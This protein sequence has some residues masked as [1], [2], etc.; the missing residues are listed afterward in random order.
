MK[1]IYL[2]LIGLGTIGTGVVKVLSENREIIRD[3]LGAELVLKKIADLDID[4]DRG[5][6]ID[7]SILTRDAGEVINDP[8]ISIVI[9]LIG[10]Y[11]PA[12]SFILKAMDN[13]KNIIT[14]NKALL[15]T[16]GREIFDKASEKGVG[17]AFEA[18]V[19]GGIPI[20]KAVKEGLAAN[21]IKS[22]LGI[23]NGTANYILSEMTNRGKDYGEC[24]KNAQEKG[25]AEA[26]PTFDVEGV[27]TAHKLAILMTLC[28]GTPI[29]ADDIYTEGITGITPL[30]IRFAAQF[31]Y[32]IK[33]LAISKEKSGR[34]EARVH[35]TMIP[36]SHMLA[37]VDGVYNA[38]FLRGNAVGA[39]MFTG[40]GAGMMPT[41]SAVVGDIIDI[42]RDI[43]KGVSD[44]VPAV[45]FQKKGIK[46]IALT[47]MDNLEVEYYLRFSVVDRPGV[48]S[49]IS[50]V[51]GAH[52]ISIASVIQEGRGKGEAVPLVI[53]THHARERDMFHALNEIGKLDVILNNTVVL[54][55]EDLPGEGE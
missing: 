50:G 42:A 53:I 1:K 20:I 16:Y 39:L 38:V 47:T 18:S 33:L 45:S 9:E 6:D 26:D 32:K 29:S 11:E 43:Q 36:A 41:A 3:R 15:S 40:K 44:R 14:A 46:N 21:R 2:G 7:K 30:D 54:R 24:L 48:L 28:Y 10:G 17:I 23:I 12:K 55:I 8:D 19:G 25:Y 13:G 37:A 31:G 49:K 52:N 35:P 27:D 34:I 51:L 22:I 4:M 5:L